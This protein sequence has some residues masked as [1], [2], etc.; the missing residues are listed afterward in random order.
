MAF[1]VGFPLAA[2]RRTMNLP[3][4][5]CGA[6]HGTVRLLSLSHAK[7]TRIELSHRAT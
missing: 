5:V 7:N 4:K 6:L 3:G 1:R 2:F